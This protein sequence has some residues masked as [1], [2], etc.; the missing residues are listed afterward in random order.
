VVF[1]AGGVTVALSGSGPG[2][3]A[4]SRTGGATGVGA[5]AFA[6]AAAARQQAAAWVARQVSADAIVACDPAMCAVL[7]G[8]HVAAGRLLV[9]SPARA[10]PLG[11]DLVVAAP[12]VRSQFGAR[13]TAV[14][15]PVTLATFGSGAADRRPG[16]G[17]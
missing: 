12:A 7:Q 13:L 8:R 11:S 2:K 15:A 17:T 16:R 1:V 10:A 5:G 4:T 9:L 3:Q 14:Y 6:A